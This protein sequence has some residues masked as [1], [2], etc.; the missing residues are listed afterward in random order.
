MKVKAKPKAQFITIEGCEGVGKSTAQQ[1]L[2]SLLEERGIPVTLTREPGG[3]SLGEVLREV[4]ISNNGEPPVDLAELLLVYAARAQHLEQVIMPALSNGRWVVCDR[5]ADTTYA[6]QGNGRGIPQN[7]IADLENMVQGSFRPDKVFLLDMEP[8]IG[9]LRAE[10][11]G[12]LDRF[13]KEGPAF[14][15]R[16]RAGYLKKAK[17]NPERYEI[18]AA[19]RKLNLVQRDLKSGLDKLLDHG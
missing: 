1:F 3:T 13:E 15:R 5:F 8:E 10:Q 19:G 14:Y 18:I 11:R 12:E 4:L 16:A 17:E 9:L 7:K 2:A 6:Y